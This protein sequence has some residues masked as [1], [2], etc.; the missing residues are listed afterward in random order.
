MTKLAKSEKCIIYVTPK[1]TRNHTIYGTI[2]TLV[3]FGG[4]RGYEKDFWTCDLH[5]V[6][7][8]LTN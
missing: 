4:I 3:G 5:V 6:N 7:K 2:Y 1:L 8:K